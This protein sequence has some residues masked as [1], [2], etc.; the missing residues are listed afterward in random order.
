MDVERVGFSEWGDAL[1]A[2]GFEAAHTPAALSVLGDHAAGD[3]ELFVGYK[4]QHTVAMLPVVVTEGVLGRTVASPPAW[5]GLPA[6]GPLLTPNS[7]KRR[8]QERA[9]RRF[10]QAIHEALDLDDP[11]ARVQLRCSPTYADP[12][13]YAWE[14]E[15]L[16]VAF[17]HRID[18]SDRT[19]AD[20]LAEASED[21][22]RSVADARDLDVSVTVEGVDAAKTVVERL[23]SGAIGVD[24]TDPPPWPYVR[25]LVSALEH[26]ARTYVV[27]GP[28]DEFRGGL[29]VLYSND[30]AM[31][32]LGGGQSIG[33][34]D[35]TPLLHWRV[36]EDVA[37]APPIESVSG[38]DFGGAN[39]RTAASER[40][41]FGGRLVTTYV[42]ESENPAKDVARRAFE[43]ADR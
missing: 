32:W 30:D 27:R 28:D 2:D 20:A 36:M 31:R 22:Q 18:L 12:R 40:C 21:V 10:S 16:D 5:T 39:S 38:Y 43:Y 26:R 19:P 41:E 29:V 8:K 15:V 7:P 3:L 34:T 42:I 24:R 35:A 11:T 37:E 6:L 14:G 13:P 23:R 9:N 17:T 1:P 33:G 4:G 25:D